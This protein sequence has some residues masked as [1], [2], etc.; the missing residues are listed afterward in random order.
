MTWPY[1]F[2]LFCE[3][4]HGL[5]QFAEMMDEPPVI[6]EKAQETPY[7]MDIFWLGTVNYFLNF[8]WVSTDVLFADHM[9]KK[10]DLFLEEMAFLWLEFEMDFS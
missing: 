3:L 5:G 4:N 1:L 10:R 8:L 7:F 6:A 9:A 2:Y